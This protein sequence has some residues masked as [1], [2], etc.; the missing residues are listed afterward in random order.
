MTDSFAAAAAAIRSFRVSLLVLPL[1]EHKV[2]QL[3]L[4]VLHLLPLPPPLQIAGQFCEAAAAA[5]KERT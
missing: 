2:F 5:A 1:N 3:G 4:L